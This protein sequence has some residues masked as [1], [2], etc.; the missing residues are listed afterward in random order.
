[1]CGEIPD[2][3]IGENFDAVGRD[4]LHGR[5][6]RPAKSIPLGDDF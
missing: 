6:L 5:K 1:L 4:P 3:R 2:Q